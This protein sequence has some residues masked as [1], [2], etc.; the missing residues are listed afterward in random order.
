MVQWFVHITIWIANKQYIIQVKGCVTTDPK[1]KLFVG[2]SDSELNN[3][4]CAII[5]SI[6]LTSK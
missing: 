2:Y 1:N 5:L 3:C 6:V 4:N